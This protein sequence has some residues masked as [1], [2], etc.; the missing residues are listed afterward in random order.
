MDSRSTGESRLKIL[1]GIP[2]AIFVEDVDSF[3]KKS[4]NESVEFVLKRL[5]EQHN[6]YK[7]METNLLSRKKKLRS[8]IPDIEKSLQIL[9]VL[10]QKSQSQEKFDTRFLLTDQVYASAKVEPTKSVCLWLGANVMLEYTLE[11]AEE[12]LKKNLEIAKNSNIQVD[13]DLDFLRDQLTITE[14]NM[15]RVYNWDV[16]RRQTVKSNAS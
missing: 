14:V 13:N 16:K 9:E 12:L 1:A 10:K 6:K 11:E 7:F 2:E 4:E 15:A 5:D 3:M 8:Q